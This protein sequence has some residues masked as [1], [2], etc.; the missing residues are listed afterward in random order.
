M[1]VAGG[2]VVRMAPLAPATVPLRT[3]D[4]VLE[5]THCL[6]AARG[7]LRGAEDTFVVDP[8]HAV[9][10]VAVAVV[11][12]T[13]VWLVLV[14]TLARAI[15]HWPAL[16][17]TAMHIHEKRQKPS[18]EA[19][20]AAEFLRQVNTELALQLAPLQTAPMNSLC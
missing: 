10:N 2:F 17:A 12:P 9:V 13:V 4:P 5:V 1:L 16:L 3:N 18:V 7:M 15:L 8:L 19:I 14:A 11:G 20:A 6:R